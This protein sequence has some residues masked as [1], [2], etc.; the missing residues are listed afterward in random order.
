MD[1]FGG[2]LCRSKFLKKKK[3][4]KRCSA[5]G[6]ASFRGHSAG[7]YRYGHVRCTITIPTSCG[8]AAAMEI[9]FVE[10]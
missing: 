9:T 1:D 2:K 3:A 4:M 7:Y 8:G 10:D 6:V 5:T